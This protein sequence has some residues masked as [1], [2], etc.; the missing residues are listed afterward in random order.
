[1]VNEGAVKKNVAKGF[2]AGSWIVVQISCKPNDVEDI[3]DTCGGVDND[4]ALEKMGSIKAKN[5]GFRFA[6]LSDI[7][8]ELIEEQLAVEKVVENVQQ[9]KK[10]LE[11]SKKKRDQDFSKL[12]TRSCKG[13]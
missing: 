7:S 11:K 1:M 9:T 12:I 10:Q 3:C 6:S 5:Q 13:I 2:L 4:M 8:L